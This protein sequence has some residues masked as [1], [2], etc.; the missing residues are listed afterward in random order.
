M[1]HGVNGGFA[2]YVVARPDQLYRVPA[3]FPLEEA[4]ISEP[5]AAAIQAVTEL[6]HVRIGDTA[7]VSVP[8]PMGLLCL[9]LLVAEGV[10]V[11]VAGAAGDDA[12]LDAALRFGAAKIV[13][14]GKQSLL[15]TAKRK[16]AGLVWMLLLNVPATKHRFVV[17]LKLCDPWDVIHKSGFAD[18]KSSSPWIK[19]FSNNLS[20]VGRFVTRPKPGTE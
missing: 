5:F 10:K 12:R 2:R 13:D 9:K 16:P 4:A 1:G 18:T 11:I 20:F 7:L 6:T 3:N 14:V 15:D 19:C 8:A 17:A